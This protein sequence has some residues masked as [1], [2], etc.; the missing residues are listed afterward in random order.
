MVQDGQTVDFE[1]FRTKW[2][3][4]TERP[5]MLLKVFQQHNDQMGALAGAV[6]QFSP[7]TLERYNTSRDHTEAFLQWK[8]KIADIDIKKLNYEFV[9]DLEF[10]L[11]TVRKCN[12]NT[13]IK[14]ISNLRKI[15]NICLRRGWLLRAPFLGF[16]MTKLEV[17]RNARTNEELQIMA[18]K[19]FPMPRLDHVRDIFLFSCYTGLAYADVKKLKRTEIS[20]G[21]DGGYWIF[22]NRQKTDTRSRI[23]LLP[24]ALEIIEKYKDNPICEQSSAVPPP[25]I[26]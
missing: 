24:F 7:A 10:W 14:Y 21:I 9:C 25:G 11:K 17:E 23:P 13:T 8:Y 6:K 22:T 20:R 4:I 12:H 26:E 5:R 1:N 19:V 3:C 18:G 15:V 16:K 2:L